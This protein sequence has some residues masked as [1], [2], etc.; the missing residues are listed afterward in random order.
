MVLPKLAPLEQ[1]VSC[2]R[3][4][5]GIS[6]EC[7]I[8]GVHCH[9]LVGTGT[10]IMLVWP[11]I[12]PNTVRRKRPVWTDTTAMLVTEGGPGRVLE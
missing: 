5:G 3:N 8:E 1:R 6:V 11:G 2:L 4:S 7:R 9:V 12:L 10:K